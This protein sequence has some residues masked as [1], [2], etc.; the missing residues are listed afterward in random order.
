MHLAAL[1]AVVATVMGCPESPVVPE[2]CLDGVRNGTESDI[3]CGGECGAS[4]LLGRACRVGTDC[5][6]GV[7][8][9]GICGEAPAGCTNGALDPGESDVDC[10]GTSCPACG[11]GERC[12]A[13]ADCESGSCVGDRCVPMSDECRNDMLDPGESDVDCGGPTCAACALG[14]TCARDGDCASGACEAGTCIDACDNGAADPG[15]AD[16]DCGGAACD[17]CEDGSS[18][19]TPTDC[20]GGLCTGGRCASAPC[21]NGILDGRETD[22]DCGGLDCSDCAVGRACVRDRDCATFVC[23]AGVCAT[24]ASTCTNGDQDGTETDV[25][26]GGAAC[27]PCDR[28]SDC[29]TGDDCITLLCEGVIF[30]R[31]TGEETCSDGVMGEDETD[32]DCGGF[33]CAPC[34]P[35]SRCGFETDCVDTTY[36]SD[37]TGLCTTYGCI[38]GVMSG[39]ETGVDCG[40]PSCTPCAAGAGCALDRDCVTGFCNGST[41]GAEPCTDGARS[42]GETGLDCGGPR[43]GACADGGGCALSRDCASG[44]C[45]PATSLCAP[46]PCAGLC[47]CMGVSVRE[48]GSCNDGVACTTRDVCT[49][50]VCAGV[51]VDCSSMT[52]GCRA[53]V[54]DAAT[55]GCTTTAA[56]NGTSCSDG[57]ACTRGDVCTGGTCG[58]TAVDCAAMTNM[59]NVGMCSAST[60]TCS[61]VPV[62]D[63][64]A[65]N[66][67]LSCTVVDT[68]RGGTCT[69]VGVGEICNA[70]DDDCDGTNNNTCPL[71]APTTPTFTVATALETGPMESGAYGGTTERD[72]SCA[73]GEVLVGVELRMS[74][75]GGDWPRRFRGLC[76]TLRVVEDRSLPLYSYYLGWTEGTLRVVEAGSWSEPGSTNSRTQCPYD[77]VMVG[78]QASYGAEM[79]SVQLTC[80]RIAVSNAS[81]TTYAR[82]GASVA[83]TPVAGVPAGSPGELRVCPATHPLLVGGTIIG[84]G[85]PRGMRGRCAAP[86]GMVTRR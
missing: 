34:G 18:C 46:D 30:P 78:Y 43:C 5:V 75:G 16:V 83:V 35:G 4:C 36:C 7:C 48:G 9:G 82:V 10:G 19:T 41:C 25:D 68:C 84:N 51:A 61:A 6:L 15:E 39:A 66:D 60:G 33:D 12:A 71:E 3:D 1:L 63:G 42:A 74:P 50:G 67:G 20:A 37:V 81:P 64:V 29:V 23:N 31:C 22:V 59:C 45:D 70:T 54:C 79:G 11:L 38:D 65:C 26:C 76:S 8:T 52:T 24:P 58:G 56:P 72:L 57:Q 27:P 14:A 13:G 80:Q 77:T 62:A 86:A 49:G 40:G 17:P 85:Y 69:G 2:Q 21:A 32:V 28:F 73:A 47:T 53:G 55:G 44:Y